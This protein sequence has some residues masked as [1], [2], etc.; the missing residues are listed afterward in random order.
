MVTPPRESDSMPGGTAVGLACQRAAANVHE[1]EHRQQRNILVLLE[2]VGE[3]LETGADPAGAEYVILAGAHG[4]GF[5]I[6]ACVATDGR[7]GWALV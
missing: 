3:I 2:Q 5:R 6:A 7:V 4:A 1:A